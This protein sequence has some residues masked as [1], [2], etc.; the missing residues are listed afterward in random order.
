VGQ[1]L[2]S[3]GVSVGMSQERVPPES[4]LANQLIGWFLGATCCSA[5]SKVPPPRGAGGASQSPAVRRGVV[6]PGRAAGHQ[7]AC[8]TSDAEGPRTPPD[9]VLGTWDVEQDPAGEHSRAEVRNVDSLLGLLADLRA[10]WKVRVSAMQTLL[11]VYERLELASSSYMLEGIP[12]FCR[13]LAGQVQRAPGAP[14]AAHGHTGCTDPG[15]SEPDTA[16]GQ[17]SALCCCAGGVRN[18][19]EVGCAAPEAGGDGSGRTVR[20]TPETHLRD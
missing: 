1:V 4:D 12:V 16:P 11:Q 10:D 5:R 18:N 19:Q 20:I 6:F 2:L 13:R 3:E 7:D 9:I 8:V 14:K 15:F 17:R